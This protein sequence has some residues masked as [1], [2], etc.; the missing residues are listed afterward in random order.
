MISVMCCFRVEVPEA[1]AR[2]VGPHFCST[3]PSVA[4]VS[5]TAVMSLGAG[6]LGLMGALLGKAFTSTA[7]RV[8]LSG[9]PCALIAPT[10]ILSRVEGAGQ[11]ASRESVPLPL[12][13]LQISGV[14]FSSLVVSFLYFLQID[15]YFSS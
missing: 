11:L 4:Q 6:L 1:V 9:S 10:D 3:Y 14:R 13:S 7:W 2:H 12:L 8:S 5:E 15:T